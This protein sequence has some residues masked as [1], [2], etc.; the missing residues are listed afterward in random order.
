MILS[1]SRGEIRDAARP[2]RVDDAMTFMPDELKAPRA[3]A[4]RADDRPAAGGTH[5]S[6]APPADVL[7]S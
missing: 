3:E 7:L 2:Y 1:R 5:D 6:A 4:N